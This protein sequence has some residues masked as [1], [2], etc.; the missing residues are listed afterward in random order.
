M[1]PAVWPGS[2]TGAQGLGTP[3]LRPSSG[4]IAAPGTPRLSLGRAQRAPLRS[5]HLDPGQG[6]PGAG[7]HS[8][9]RQASPSSGPARHGPA[10]HGPLALTSATCFAFSSF[11]FPLYEQYPFARF[12][13]GKKKCM[14]SARCLIDVDKI[15]L[16]VLFLLRHLFRGVSRQLHREPLEGGGRVCPSSLSPSPQHSS[17]HRSECLLANQR[18]PRGTAGRG[19]LPAL[20]P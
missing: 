5:L 18:G 4:P 3:A 10:R 6:G 8:E 17:D 15:V 12:L 1:P 14:K 9:E 2:Y 11:C 7:G 13:W 16:S 19:A 20:P